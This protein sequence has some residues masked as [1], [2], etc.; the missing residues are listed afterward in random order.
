MRNSY[1]CT[2]LFLT[3]FSINFTKVS[4]AI[5]EPF[6]EDEDDYHI[7]DLLSRHIWVTCYL[8]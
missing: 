1:P 3:L 5:D 8:E 7:D 2:F 4:H 6:G